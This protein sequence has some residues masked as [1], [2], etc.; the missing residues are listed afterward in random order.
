M[1]KHLYVNVFVDDFKLCIFL[2]LSV[3]SFALPETEPG[4]L[5]AQE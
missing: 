3:Q 5:N 2:F 4:R 1:Q